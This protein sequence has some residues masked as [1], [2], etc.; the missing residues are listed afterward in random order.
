MMWPPDRHGD[1]RW[2]QCL[3]ALVA[4][5]NHAGPDD[6]LA[7]LRWLNGDEPD[8]TTAATRDAG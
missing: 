5:W 6:T 3:D 7:T 4:A 8:E 2:N 1:N